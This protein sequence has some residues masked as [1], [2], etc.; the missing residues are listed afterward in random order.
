M[1]QQKTHNDSAQKQKTVILNGCLICAFHMIRFRFRNK[2]QKNKERKERKNMSSV[3]ICS[4]A[5]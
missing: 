2:K 1:S 3:N 5:A 4:W